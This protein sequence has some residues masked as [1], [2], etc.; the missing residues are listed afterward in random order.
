MKNIILITLSLTM[1]HYPKYE[2]V[3]HSVF[4]PAAIYGMVFLLWI[5]WVNKFAIINKK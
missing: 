2:E 4:F 3:M 5:I 1:Y